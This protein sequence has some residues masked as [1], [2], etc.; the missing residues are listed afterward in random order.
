MKQNADVGV[1]GVSGAVASKKPYGD[2]SMA[3]QEMQQD[4][5]MAVVGYPSPFG[6]QNAQM[7]S[8]LG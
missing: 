1:S 3:V 4:Q 7:T 8:I 5:L 6:V 2:D